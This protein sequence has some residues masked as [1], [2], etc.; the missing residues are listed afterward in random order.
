MDANPGNHFFLK[1]RQKNEEEFQIT[2]PEMSEDFIILSNFNACKNYEIVMV[3]VDGQYRT[4]SDLVVTP[5]QI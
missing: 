5:T 2:Q 3:A 1:Y 4:E